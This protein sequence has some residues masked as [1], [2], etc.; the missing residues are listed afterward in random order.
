MSFIFSIII[1]LQWV[2][3]IFKH[4]A[5]EKTKCSVLGVAQRVRTQLRLGED[6][7]SIPGFAQWL[8]DPALPQAAAQVTDLVLLW[9][10][11]RLQLQLGFNP[12]P[13]TSI[14]PRWGHEKVKKEREGEM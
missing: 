6:V 12:G 4:T 9:L 2:K 11:R 1:S 7:G 5:K 14:C 10:R 13:G 3:I 8:R